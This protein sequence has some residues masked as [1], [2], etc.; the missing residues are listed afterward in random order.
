MFIRV[1][2][3]SRGMDHRTSRLVLGLGLGSLDGLV[4][5]GRRGDSIGTDVRSCSIAVRMFSA[6]Q[7]SSAGMDFA[8]G[9][10]A[11]PRF[12]IHS[13]A[14]DLEVLL[15]IAKPFVT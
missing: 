9:S 1:T 2:F 12:T 5:A 13:E 14:E 6:A 10:E 7:V 11:V 8:A 4:G 15:T 3:T